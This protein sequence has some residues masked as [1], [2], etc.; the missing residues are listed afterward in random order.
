MRATLV[1]VSFESNR[2]SH[3]EIGSVERVTNK[4]AERMLNRARMADL[5]RMAGDL[6]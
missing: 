6:R 2:W 1:G 4:H 3:R 5:A